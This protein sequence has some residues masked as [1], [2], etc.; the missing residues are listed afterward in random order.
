MSRD[1]VGIVLL[2]IGSCMLM[3]RRCSFVVAQGTFHLASP[4][5]VGRTC[6]RHQYQPGIYTYTLLGVAIRNDFALTQ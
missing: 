2:W 3:R 6:L 4:A 1:E 5:S